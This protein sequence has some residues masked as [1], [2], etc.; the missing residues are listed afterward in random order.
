[1]NLRHNARSGLCWPSPREMGSLSV[2]L[3]IATRLQRGSLPPCLACGLA[4]TG[5]VAEWSANPP[6]DCLA[7]LPVPPPLSTAPPLCRL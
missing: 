5:D 7:R 2:P 1:M 6:R 3:G 4:S